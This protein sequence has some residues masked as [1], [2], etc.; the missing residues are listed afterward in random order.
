MKQIRVERL[1]AKLKSLNMGVDDK[2]SAI[3]P[4]LLETAH[5]PTVACAP[6]GC[7]PVADRIGS[8]RVGV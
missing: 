3:Y 4:E 6:T 8:G 2:H 5:L 1:H 7:Y